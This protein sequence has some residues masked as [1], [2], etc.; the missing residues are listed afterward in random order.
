MFSPLY[1]P[2]AP[3][4][5]LSPR[6][7]YVSALSRVR[8]AEMEYAAYLEHNKWLA[9]Q[10]QNEQIRAARALQAKLEYVM[11]QERARHLQAQQR[12][13]EEAVKRMQMLVLHAAVSSLLDGE[14][15]HDEPQKK[16][17]QVEPQPANPTPKDARKIADS[18]SGPQ[19]QRRNHIRFVRRP[20]APVDEPVPAVQTALKRRLGLEPN[21]QVHA[22]IQSILSKLSSGPR[23]TDVVPKSTAAIHRV[24]GAFSRLSSEF[25]FPSKLDFVSEASASYPAAKLPYTPRNAPVRH[26]ESALNDL[27]SQL[28]AIDSEGN[29][30]VR[31]QRKEVVRMVENALEDLDRLVEGRWKLQD[32]QG[33]NTRRDATTPTVDADT[34]MVTISS[35]ALDTD[36]SQI[37]SIPEDESR[38]SPA[39]ELSPVPSINGQERASQAPVSSIGIE[40]QEEPSH[41]E[42]SLLASES[43]T[44][45]TSDSESQPPLGEPQL[46]TTIGVRADE[47]RTIQVPIVAPLSSTSLCVSGE[48]SV[49]Q[50]AV[51]DPSS[52]GSLS[53]VVP[54]PDEDLVVVEEKDDDS[55]SSWSEIQD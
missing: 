21:V 43:A 14:G 22:A 32:T 12:R 1:A 28:D 6:D 50:A 3:S 18:C 29:A 15:I 45:A 55:I 9:Q 5:T 26:Y 2:Y 35:A 33:N 47:D 24:A 4:H 20:K 17:L 31:Q 38:P 19:L 8:Q 25:A 44:H 30:T 7:R 39:R 10:R 13:N 42:S 46:P 52:S 16:H 36:V 51:V 41:G 23:D 34:S 54:L 49:I 11:H 27:L 48:E 37:A 53:F 40:E